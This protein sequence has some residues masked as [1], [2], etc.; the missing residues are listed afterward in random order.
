MERVIRLDKAN[1]RLVYLTRRADQRYWE[2]EHRPWAKKSLIERGDRFVAEETR[3]YL[4]LGAKV[5]DA[6]CG[7]GATVF[8]L[9]KA[10]FN[11]YG[12]DYD[13]K[14]VVTIKS[15]FPDLNV[16][17]AD[18]C[19]MPFSEGY[20]DGVW[21][22]GV[23]EHFYDGYL[24]IILETRRVLRPGGYLFL[25]VP[26]I[27]PTKKFKMW[28]GHYDEVRDADLGQFFQFA[29]HP[30]DTIDAVTDMGFTL[31]R[32]FGRSGSMGLYED[33]NS[34]SKLFFL[35]PDSRDTLSRIMWRAADIVL[36]KISYH[37]RYFVFKRDE[38]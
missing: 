2:E 35:K 28:L 6:G 1:D 23:I 29:F 22:L 18:V 9:R 31:I 37:I 11:A 26:S 34:L 13:E 30:K 19:K 24:P 20:F 25:T 12:I 21:S 36:R 4:P 32:S 8:G 5:I 15:S 3:K 38:G 27:S 33:A 14:T 10:G 7:T 16:Q 17:V